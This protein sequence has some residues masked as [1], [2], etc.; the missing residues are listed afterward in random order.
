MN[1]VKNNLLELKPIV[2]IL[3]IGKSIINGFWKW[4]LVN[5]ITKGNKLAD[6][7]EKQGFEVKK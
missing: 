7:L 2:D 3:R 4:L 5:A 1:D 6:E